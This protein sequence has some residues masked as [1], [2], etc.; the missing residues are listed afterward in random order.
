M[1]TT[2]CYGNDYIFSLVTNIMISLALMQFCL[3]VL[4]H[5]FTYTCRFD[6]VATLYTLRGRAMMLCGTTAGQD[7][8]LDDDIALL[9]NDENVYN[10]NE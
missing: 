3:A 2:Y 6:I 7:E 10:Y 1:Y 9:D 8:Y 4:Y 5:F